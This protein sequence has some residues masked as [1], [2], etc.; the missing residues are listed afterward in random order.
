MDTSSTLKIR[1]KKPGCDWFVTVSGVPQELA[2]R[3][4]DAENYLLARESGKHFHSTL[5]KGTDPASAAE[6]WQPMTIEHDADREKVGDIVIIFRKHPTTKRWMVLVEPD[7]A[8][9]TEIQTV[10][11]WRVP[12]SSVDNVTQSVK[13]PVSHS[14]WEYTNTRRLGGKQVK[15]H[16]VIAEWSAQQANKM[17]DVYDFAETL[18]GPGL[19][20]WAKAI[21]NM[22]NRP[23]I[24]I[25]RHWRTPAE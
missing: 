2:G 3:E 1:F 24:E 19:A 21:H 22:P 14:G 16:Y 18:D 17:M 6:F 9:V 13:K 11:T 12:R 25:F 23:A 5:V 10:T 8:Y 20:S 15:T 4:V 7:I